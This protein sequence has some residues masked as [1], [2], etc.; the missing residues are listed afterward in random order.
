MAGNQIGAV[1]GGVVGGIAGSFVG[2]PAL[3][4]S[5][6]WAA[7]GIIGGALD[8]PKDQITDFGSQAFPQ[9]NTALRGKTIPVLFGTNRVASNIV[10]QGNYQTIRSEETTSDGGKAGGSGGGGK[11]PQSRTAVYTYKMDIV[12]H[13]GFSPTPVDLLKIWNN[14][15]VIDSSVTTLIATSNSN[16][17]GPDPSF[18]ENSTTLAFTSAAFYRGEA[19][20]SS[21]WS[22]LTSG[23]GYDV[24]WPYTSW[25]GLSELN[26]G[27]RPVVPQLSFEVGPQGG[28]FVPESRVL[29]SAEEAFHNGALMRGFSGQAEDIYGNVWVFGIDNE[30]SKVLDQ[31]GNVLATHTWLDLATQ[32]LELMDSFPHGTTPTQGGNMVCHGALVLNG[33]RVLF[34]FQAGGAPYTY[35][36]GVAQ[37][38]PDGSLVVSGACA[39]WGI[40]G[41][42][43]EK[44]GGNHLG[45]AFLDAVPDEDSYIL[46]FNYT[47]VGNLRAQVCISIGQMEGVFKGARIEYSGQSF[48]DEASYSA[49]FQKSTGKWDSAYSYGANTDPFFVL[50]E[51]GD[52]YLY[53]YSGPGIHTP[54]GQLLT[55]RDAFNTDRGGLVR[56]QL[57]QSNLPTIYT[58]S[59]LGVFAVWPDPKFVNGFVDESAVAYGSFSD[60]GMDFETGTTS[61]REVWY[62]P[63][64]AVVDRLENGAYIVIF[65]ALAN[66]D[67]AYLN[68]TNYFTRVKLRAYIYNPSNGQ[69]TDYERASGILYGVKDIYGSSFIST[70]PEMVQISIKREGNYLRTYIIGSDHVIRADFGR[71]I[72]FGGADITPPEIIREI[73]VNAVFGLFPGADI[74][75]TA[76][77]NTAASYCESNGIKV[78]CQYVNEGRGW[79][80][81]EKLLA[82]YDG[83]LNVNASE[84]TIK[85]GIMDYNAMPV[86]TIDNDHLLRRDP[87]RPPVNT[88]K[89]APQDTYNKVR[90]V[91]IDRDLEYKQNAV[92][93]DDE[94]DQDDNGVRLREFPGDFVMPG[95][96]A[97]R[98]A[99]RALW[100]NL[101]AR[102]RH[103]F[104]LGWKDSDLEPGDVVTLVDSHTNLHQVIQL[105]RMVE[106]ERGVFEVA[107][108]Q[109]LQYI[110]GRQPSQVSS[111]VW[112]FLD[113]VTQSS[114]TN[115]SSPSVGADWGE[116]RGL[117][118]ARA[119]ELP[120]EY[121]ADGQSRLYV[122]W[123][124]DGKAAGATLYASTDGITFASAQQVTPYPICGRILAD[125]PATDGVLTNVPLVLYPFST[126]VVSFD[127][128]GTLNDIDESAMHNGLGLLWVNS[129]MLAY[130]NVTLVSQNR[131]TLGKVYRGWGGTVI[132][133]VSS[134]DRFWKHGGGIF[135]QE[136]TVD[137][138]GGTF[139]YKV[140]P[141]D[142]R[143]IEY[144]VASIEAGS[145]TIQGTFYRPSLPQVS[146]VNSLRGITRQNVGSA[147]D[148]TAT[149]PS[150]ARQSG[151]GVGGYGKN[152]GGYGNFVPDAS[153]LGWRV[154]IVGSGGVV[155]RSTF[156]TTPAFAY[157]NSNNAADNGAWRGNIAVKVTPRNQYG[158]ALRS[159][160]T[161]LELFF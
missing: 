30:S 134:G 106:V 58:S 65:Y 37:V 107:A 17:L 109:L 155:V 71:L 48:V 156:V 46:A 18:D 141:F 4:F 39:A 118:Y 79:D 91:Y 157:T 115:V 61:A 127:F 1:V 40:T 20:P 148:I 74:I 34:N 139:Y 41:L 14:G 22:P 144:N 161:S 60:H 110:P 95:W 142:F 97:T 99:S 9:F 135:R 45:F 103:Q 23:V 59:N 145:Y 53:M 105:T 12:Y 51:G 13:L 151:Y 93:E 116:V 81:I 16:Y 11:G 87:G 57:S 132:G 82:I 31:N 101:Y 76:T 94:V 44:A 100:N 102:D 131:Y 7:G 154:E 75:D 119:Y 85:F 130:Q 80:Y 8:P 29:W 160:V 55:D 24:R 38:Q 26:L 19:S 73:L 27:D 117:N 50:P 32:A 159:A 124:P 143:G 128:N 153:S 123:V 3:G 47:F 104:Y 108:G 146:Q 21:G 62:M 84:G 136:F 15:T 56:W 138:I 2:M 36:F 158:D 86:R 42:F 112:T 67:D 113:T 121:E 49:E 149:W 150:G 122:G 33:T 147:G 92:E 72:L 77:Y 89:G 96:L 69:F 120:Y 70:N 129:E 66:E 140:V 10:W 6:G 68:N 54:S 90:V 98:M 83:Y 114:Y 88:T 137:R 133:A 28:G 52:L 152:A 35:C 5:I 125:L 63:K 64:P 126:S 25:I 111:T 78:S 43:P